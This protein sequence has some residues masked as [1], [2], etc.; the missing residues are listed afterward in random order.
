[1]IYRYLL[2]EW[3]LQDDQSWNLCESQ[4]IARY[5]DRVAPSPSLVQ[6]DLK[7]PEKLW[8]LVSIIASIGNKL[9]TYASHACTMTECMLSGFKAIEIQV[10]KPRWKSINEG[11][12]SPDECRAQIESSGGAQGLRDFFQTLDS[13]RHGKGPFLIGSDPTWPDFFLY[14]LVSDLLAVPDA[15]LAPPRYVLKTQ[16]DS[17]QTAMY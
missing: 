5:L 7:V 4:A 8:E 13:L 3:L 14:P 9:S 6:A 12:E 17:K 1:M 16:R 2:K 11:H 10:V 15:D